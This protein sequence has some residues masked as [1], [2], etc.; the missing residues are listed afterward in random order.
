MR[1]IISIEDIAKIKDY[2]V[3]DSL[4]VKRGH[5]SKA[6][7]DLLGVDKSE[8][9]KARAD[10][11]RQYVEVYSYNS[12]VAVLICEHYYQSTKSYILRLKELLLLKNKA[13]GLSLEDIAVII[14]KKLFDREPEHVYKVFYD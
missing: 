12:D 11:Y 6:V 10:F 4:I 14:F 3:M 5:K 9:I 13:L 1:D 8:V 7:Y 2:A